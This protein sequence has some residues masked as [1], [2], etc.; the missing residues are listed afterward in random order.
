MKCSMCLVLHDTTCATVDGVDWVW[1]TSAE[2]P[3]TSG[4]IENLEFC[5]V[6][7]LLRDAVRQSR[8]SHS[9]SSTFAY[10]YPSICWSSLPSLYRIARHHGPGSISVRLITSRRPRAMSDKSHNSE[11]L[12]PF[13]PCKMSHCP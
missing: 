7:V 9:L 1:M 6:S 5:R 12:Q 10:P 13:R 2:I 3:E 4:V 11:L 8:P